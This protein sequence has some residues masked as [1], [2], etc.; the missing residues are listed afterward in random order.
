VTTML[1]AALP[2]ELRSANRG[3]RS[4]PKTRR[5]EHTIQWYRKP[6]SSSS[7]LVKIGP[8]TVVP[9]AP[10]GSHRQR[11]EIVIRGPESIVAAA[12]TEQ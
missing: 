6:T 5:E 7:H 9:G 3:I 10:D 1:G 12:S 11:R 4:R 2:A 8:A